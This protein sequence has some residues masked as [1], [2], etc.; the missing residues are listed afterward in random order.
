VSVRRRLAAPTVRWLGVVALAL[1]AVLAGTFGALTS[2]GAQA[3]ED[4]L[5]T[6]PPTRAV[7]NVRDAAPGDSVQV[8]VVARNTAGTE[9][10]VQTTLTGLTG[11]SLLLNGANGLHASIDVCSE[12]WN[13]VITPGQAGPTYECAGTTRTLA[14]RSPIRSLAE[15]PLAFPNVLEEGEL[16]SVRATIDLPPTGD[17][18][19]EN[20]ASSTV[21]LDVQATLIEEPEDG[22]GFEDLFYDELAYTGFGLLAVLTLLGTGLVLG[23][24]RL[25]RK[26]EHGAAAAGEVLP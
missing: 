7:A 10:V 24:R 25:R 17:N 3:R 1:L 20:L 22:T 16:V 9:L 14:T 5:E 15:R 13:A 26:A 23:G 21:Q 2:A 18:T 6:I 4:L 11:P 19:Y 8:V 12:A